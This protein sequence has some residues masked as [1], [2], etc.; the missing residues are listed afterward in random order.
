ML[1][2]VE[3]G[4]HCPRQVQHAGGPYRGELEPTVQIY[5]VECTVHLDGPSAHSIYISAD[6]MYKAWT[7]AA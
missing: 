7:L 3:L 5:A 2:V 6:C 4:R 1:L